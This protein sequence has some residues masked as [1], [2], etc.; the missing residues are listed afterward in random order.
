MML[1]H[2]R[3][4]KVH[5]AMAI[6][7]GD[8]ALTAL[9]LVHRAGHAP[10]GQLHQLA[11]PARLMERHRVMDP[12]ALA[13]L[14]ATLRLRIG[15]ADMQTLLAMPDSLVI[16]RE[17]RLPA[18]L[19]SMAVEQHFR[20]LLD[21]MLPGESG[22]LCLDYAKRQPPAQGLESWE[23][24]A[25]RRDCV[26][27]RTDLL[28]RS[29]FRVDVVETEAHAMQRAL[30]WLAGM[31]GGNS[32]SGVLLA[33]ESGLQLTLWE[34]G[35]MMNRHTLSREVLA[36]DAVGGMAGAA[37]HQFFGHAGSAAPGAAP[38][39]LWY[40]GGLLESRPAWLMQLVPAGCRPLA[41]LMAAHIPG[42][43]PEGVPDTDSLTL[44]RLLGLA[45]RGAGLVDD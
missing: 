4:A 22:Q 30:G 37:I 38:A 5:A 39:L 43:I 2:W 25:C 24:V 9:V 34:K 28:A 14:L 12:A 3:S 23:M 44:L 27:E 35:V 20:M 42:L 16:S 19:A 36:M 7:L 10:E 11:L 29:G 18:G 21:E 15:R 17:S 1:G 40:G 13:S 6:E 45:L 33:L 41:E 8:R 31:T 32:R 26:R